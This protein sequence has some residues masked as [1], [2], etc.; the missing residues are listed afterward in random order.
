MK[1]CE[2]CGNTHNGT[3]GTGRFCSVKCA[4][5]FSTKSKRK[6]INEKISKKLSGRGNGNITLICKSC[7]NEFKVSWNKRK[8]KYCSRK[9]VPNKW[10]NHDKVNWSKVNKLAYKNGNNYVAGGTTKWYN[11]KN[12]KVQGTYELRTCK[13]LDFW[14]EHGKIY[15]WEY[16]NDRIEYFYK[17]KK[18]TYLLDFKVFENE[19]DFYYIETKGFIRDRDKAKWE[20]VRNNGNKLVIWFKEDIAKEEENM[21]I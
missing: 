8:Q 6:K 18:S 10:R 17:G 14:K 11:Y 7:N 21:T 9:C 20:A 12:I 1:Q 4:R 19:N 15:D 3:Y 16:T 2:N 5:S 13:I